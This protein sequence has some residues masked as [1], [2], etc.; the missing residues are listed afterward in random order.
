MSKVLTKMSRVSMKMTRGI[1][2]NNPLNIRENPGDL[3]QWVGERATN[4]DPIFEEFQNAHHGIRAGWK[5]LLNYQKRYKA[6][7]VFDMI[8]KWAPPSENLTI[9]YAE[10]VAK[11]MHIGINERI[12]LSRNKTNGVR[13]LQAMIK[14]ENGYTPYS[15]ELVLEAINLV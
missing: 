9:Q 8:S 3:T 12:V 11:D 6:F 15:D 5:I 4:D 7:S 14:M 13:M 1:R 10:Y 2:N